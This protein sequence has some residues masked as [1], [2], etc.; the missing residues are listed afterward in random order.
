MRLTYV[1]VAIVV[2]GL[3]IA[4]LLGSDG[5]VAEI[6]G[7]APDF[8]VE[9]IGGGTFT[10][11]EAVGRPVVLNLWASWCPPCREEIPA[12]S[13]FADAH[14]ELIVIGVSVDDPVETDTR[15]FAAEIEATYPLMLGTDQVSDAYPHFGLPVT[16]VIDEN[17]IVA[18]FVNG[19]VDARI[20]TDVTTT[21]S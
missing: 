18:D 3:A 20:L 19:I 6:G 16:Y 15:R 1:F 12:I 14:P 21:D 7:P 11:S 4:W 2:V 8:T 9:V 10:L 5:P 13:A 17:G